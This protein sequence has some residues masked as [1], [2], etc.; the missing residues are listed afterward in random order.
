MTRRWE[1]QCT[2]WAADS[3]KTVIR[4]CLGEASSLHLASSDSA[5]L[6]CQ[7]IQTETEAVSKKKTPISVQQ[8]LRGNSTFPESPEGETWRSSAPLIAPRKLSKPESVE[9]MSSACEQ[10][11]KAIL[12]RAGCVYTFHIFSYLFISFHIFSYLS[13]LCRLILSLHFPF[14]PPFATPLRQHLAFKQTLRPK[15]KTSWAKLAKEARNLFHPGFHNLSTATIHNTRAT[16]CNT[17]K[18]A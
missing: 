9:D 14:S 5:E 11:C 15:H 10:R 4:C 8:S 6:I 7:L 13:T 2:T 12:F 1:V 16:E 3:A 18:K 17:T